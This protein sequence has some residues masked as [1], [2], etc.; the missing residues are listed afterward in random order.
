MTPQEE[1]DAARVKAI[2]GLART[3]AILESPEVR[4]FA[5]ILKRRRDEEDKRVHDLELTDTERRDALIRWTLI[6]DL[7]AAPT[8]DMVSYHQALGT[9]PEKMLDLF[10]D[11]MEE[12]Q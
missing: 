9:R 7:L 3:Y 8:W 6:R 1:Q 2:N 12:P 10:G 11:G 4:D 5:A